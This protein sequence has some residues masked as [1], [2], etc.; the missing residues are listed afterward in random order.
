[1]Y[2][3]DTQDIDKI[4]HRYT[5]VSTFTTGLIIQICHR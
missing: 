1:M 4:Y 3:F 5:I 2:T